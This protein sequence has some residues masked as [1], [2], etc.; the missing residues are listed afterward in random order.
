MTKEQSKSGLSRRAFFGLDLEI[1][2]I[3]ILI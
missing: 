3:H 2:Q 1:Q